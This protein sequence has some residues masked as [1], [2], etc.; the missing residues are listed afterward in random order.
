MAKNK[1][2]GQKPSTTSTTLPNVGD[3]EFVD[4]NQEKI[5][6]G[7][8]LKINFVSEGR[9][10]MFMLSVQRKGQNNQSIFSFEKKGN[11]FTIHPKKVQG[12]APFK[13][14]FNDLNNL[15]F[16][17]NKIFFDLE[18]AQVS[19]EFSMTI[20]NTNESKNKD[21]K[22][23][24]EL[25]LEVEL[26]APPKLSATASAALAQATSAKIANAPRE[27]TL[28]EAGRNKTQDQFLWIFIRNGVLD[29]KRYKKFIDMVLCDPNKLSNEKQLWNNRLPFNQIEAY[30]ILKFATDFYMKKYYTIDKS[31]E[32]E[33][34][35]TIIRRSA[36]DK[37]ALD[38]EKN[39]TKRDYDD[40]LDNIYE[41]DNKTVKESYWVSGKDYLPY[42]ETI[43][44]R[45]EPFTVSTKANSW[46]GD[47]IKEN[48]L[49]DLNLLELIWSYWH[50]EGGLVQTMNAISLR[51]QNVR[52][53]AN[54]PLAGLNIDPLRPINNLI[55]GYIE[56]ERNRLSMSRR[57]LEYQ[58]EYGISL[59]G[60]AVANIQVAESRS[61]FLPAFHNL[62][63]TAIDFYQQ[64]NYTTVIPDGFPV[65]N[66]LREVHLLLSE[67]SHNQFGSLPWAA[68]AEMFIQQWLLS[69][70]EMRE[71]LG[72]RIMMPYN[73]E[74]MDK[75]DT[76]KTIQGWNPTNIT[77]FHDLGAFG[78]QLLLSIRYGS[79]NDPSQTRD[80]AAN[81]AYYWREEIQRYV[82]AYKAATG[83]DLG[84]DV[85]D[86]RIAMPQNVE[87]YTQPSVLIGRR[88]NSLPNNRPSQLNR[89]TQRRNIERY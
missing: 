45:L 25:D 42:F 81:W 2:T 86:A 31:E 77:H 69:R 36:S 4:K 3:I 23:L 51:F 12:T 6:I 41:S 83:V 32:N 84:N 37:F 29:F 19:G 60:K 18:D 46:C 70:P 50:E 14:Y 21:F 56:D 35:N 9:D 62:L 74:W 80:N 58:Y 48:S 10:D 44:K 26:N 53:N 38:D 75:V 87:R 33:Y 78:E 65:L 64:A 71:F 34:N 52:L 66:S 15:E 72:G 30:S 63:K 7:D 67:G 55:W 68:R 39:R 22:I 57:N 40:L 88:V 82:H 17:N 61:Q 89:L 28:V 76:M 11:K 13:L 54:D 85:T 8:D 20:S 5:K 73:E 43:L 49:E 47:T 27:V 79:W 24:D 59:I 16:K 1:T